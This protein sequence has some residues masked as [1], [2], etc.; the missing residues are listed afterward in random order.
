MKKLFT[1]IAAALMAV[2]ANAAT[3]STIWEGS[4]TFDESWSGSFKVESSKFSD[5]KVGDKII[6][7]AKPETAVSWQWG[8]QVFIKTSRGGWA[9]IAPTIAVSAAGEY[10]IEVSD[11]EITIEEEKE[12]KSKV[13]VQ[14]SILK[15]LQEYGMIVQGIDA[16]VTKIEKSVYPKYEETG[17]TIEYNEYGQIMK[18][19]LANFS[20][21]DKVVFNYKVEGD[22][23]GV[24]GWGIGN[25]KSLGGN[26]TLKEIVVEGIGNFSIAFTMDELKNALDD[27]NTQYNTNGVALSLWAQKGATPSRT[28]VV[29]Y[30]A[31]ADE[32]GEETTENKIVFTEAKSA[33][34]LDGVTFGTGFVLT[35]TDKVEG[36]K[37][38][39]DS[40]K[41]YFGTV[42]NWDKYEFR[43]KTG[44]KSDSKNA[45]KLTIPAAG[46]LTIAMRSS[47]SSATRN[48]VFTQGSTELKSFE[49]KDANCT[50]GTIEGVSDKTVFNYYTIDNVAA[51]DINITYDGGT[52]FYAFILKTATGIYTIDSTKVINNG[53]IYNLAGQ[54]VNENYKGIVI[55]N[56]KKYIQK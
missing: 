24:E 8:A 27:T 48:V 35:V 46:S 53:A 54:K 6:V 40:N 32:G 18:D 1:L 21:D 3:V 39:I 37:I 25:L 12:D 4:E 26:V 29:V 14:T 44:G 19:Q 7:T 13:N 55:K 31:I 52:N 45:L 50:K 49:V 51:G 23:T 38:S 11:A 17:T 56:G 28:N 47:S 30:K 15:E 22:V 41:Q 34:Q 20:G 2:G 9:Q 10:S 16:T 36:G 43:L 33:G 5:I 42:E